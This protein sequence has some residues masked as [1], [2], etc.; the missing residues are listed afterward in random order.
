[1]A[2]SNL[3][4]DTDHGGDAASDSRCACHFDIPVSKVFGAVALLSDTIEEYSQQALTA[5]A[6]VLDSA[7]ARTEEMSIGSQLSV[8]RGE[9]SAD[10]SVSS[11]YTR[12]CAIHATSAGVHK[13]TAFHVRC[14]FDLET[15]RREL[16]ELD[17]IWLDIDMMMPRARSIRLPYELIGAVRD[18]ATGHILRCDSI[19]LSPALIAAP[20]VAEDW[21]MVGCVGLGATR[22]IIPSLPL[23]DMLPAFMACVGPGVQI[24]LPLIAA[25]MAVC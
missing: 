9:E 8:M 18:T 20:A 15:L 17:V 6:A 16:G 5:I 19:V 12:G 24:N 14:C 22:C 13:G 4:Q 10:F 3:W 25:C 1:M 2:I 23:L 11:F 7:P 21:R